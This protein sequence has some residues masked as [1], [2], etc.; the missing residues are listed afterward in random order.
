MSLTTGSSDPTDDYEYSDQEY[1]EYIHQSLTTALI[2]LAIR[3][4]NQ[5]E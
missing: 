2:N 1:W 4:R 3:L 5:T